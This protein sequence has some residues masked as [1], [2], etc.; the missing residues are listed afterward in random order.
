MTIGYGICGK[1]EAKR[2]MRATMEEFK[3][4]CDT[5]LILC[6]SVG[7]AE[8][9]LIKEYGFKTVE[10]NRVWA[11]NQQHIKQDFLENHVAKI[12]KDGDVMVCL[13]MDEVFDPTFTRSKL[14][15]LEGWAWHFYVVNLWNEGHKP[16][17]NFWNVRAWKWNGDTE[18][19]DKPLHPGLAPKWAYYI[20]QYAP[21]LLIHYGLKDKADRMRKVERYKKYDPNA[22]YCSP[23]YYKD[24]LTDD[25]EPFDEAK[26]LDDVIKEVETYK[27]AI[28]KKPVSYSNR[29]FIKIKA[30]NGGVYD[31]PAEDEQLYR[32]QGIEILLDDKVE[33]GPILAPNKLQCAICGFEAKSV[34]GLSTHKKTH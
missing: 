32:N 21:H 29:K 20:N 30:K 16:R 7:P 2:Y 13:D 9:K 11:E 25:C 1:G 31:V 27:P 24:L 19:V 15:R 18:F 17:R 33:E 8:K 23:N 34:A 12:A 14:N 5:T 3:R 22:K 10:D 28:K 4:L 6:N 26:V